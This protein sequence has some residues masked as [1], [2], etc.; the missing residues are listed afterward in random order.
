M[1]H[2]NKKSLVRQCQEALS[3]K[4]SPGSSRHLDKAAN[5]TGEKIYS[6]NTYRT[7]LNSVV[8]F[9]DYCK[10][11]HG[12]KTLT[13]CR[14]YVDEY[15][16]HRGES[17]SPWTVKLDAAAIAKTYGE[18]SRNFAPTAP[19]VRS[20]VTRSRGAKASDTHFSESKHSNMV[21]FC[22]S[23]GLRRSELQACRGTD[24][25]PCSASP[26]GYGIAVASGKGGRARVAPIY[27]DKQTAQ[28]II[29]TCTAAGDKKIYPNPSKAADIHSYRSDYACSV[30]NANARDTSQLFWCEK[31]ICR[32]DKK[33][34]EYDR[35]ALRTAS[36]ALGHN[37]E[38]VVA[39]SYLR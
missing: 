1:G 32:G 28:Q 5:A 17:C 20:D 2:K 22:R 31:Y 39:N 34:I 24:L 8:S 12:C 21:A 33:G 19:R 13:E 10:E 38:C 14:P 18:S 25:V 3:S 16:G 37:R 9:T 23:T 29:A 4:L 36:A 6:F 11:Q 7:Y 30:Y 26:V 35:A 27:A 15:L